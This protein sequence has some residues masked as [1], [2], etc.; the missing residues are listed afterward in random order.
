MSVSEHA[1]DRDCERTKCT[2]FSGDVDQPVSD[3]INVDF[4][5]INF[6]A[7]E[8]ATGRMDLVSI[9]FKVRK[10]PVLHQRLL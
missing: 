1:R 10:R 4:R 9:D 6:F 5:S 3:R 7:R 8:E 2:N